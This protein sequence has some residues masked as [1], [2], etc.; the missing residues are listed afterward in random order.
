V[1]ETAPYELRL[2]YRA[3]CDVA[4]LVRFFSARAVPGVEQIDGDVYVRSVR[5]PGGPGVVAL[6]PGRPDASDVEAKLWLQHPSDL[7]AAVAVSRCLLDLDTDPAP[8]VD[9][10][11]SDDLI[12]KIVRSAPGAR[13]PGHAGPDEI[14]IRAVLGQQVSL[15]GAATLAARLVSAYGEPLA[16]PVGSV[17]HVF[18]SAA[19]LAGADPEQ[20]AMPW[21]RRRAL[22]GLAKALEDG[23]PVLD[24]GVMA[25]DEIERRLLALPGIGP[26]TVAYIAMRALRDA[27]AFMPTDLGVR[28]GLERLGHDGRPPSAER[29]AER[30]RPY[31]AYATQHLWAR[32]AA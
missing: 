8:I 9:A 15:A 23:D 6:G 31:R 17:T 26:W 3:P 2:P 7:D 1:A 32:A 29:I 18:P 14:A 21:S 19:A 20:L 5:L 24:T 27:D 12:G 16:D 13:V 10:L 25:Q 30:W 28:H 4:G 22:I 11:G